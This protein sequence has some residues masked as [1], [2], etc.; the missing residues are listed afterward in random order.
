MGTLLDVMSEL[1]EVKTNHDTKYQEL[2]T[3]INEAKPTKIIWGYPDVVEMT[4]KDG[5]VHTY[6]IIELLDGIKAFADWFKET[7]EQEE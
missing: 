1:A 5:K 2:R 4:D 7:K 6:S 3:S